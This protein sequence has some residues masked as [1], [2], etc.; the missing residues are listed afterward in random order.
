VGRRKIAGVLVETRTK[1][2]ILAYAVLGIGINANSDVESIKEISAISVSMQ[3]LLGKRI[4]RE[5]L[6]IELL[7][8]VERLYDSQSVSLLSMLREFD[9]SRGRRVVVRCQGKEEIDGVFEDYEELDSVRIGT[10]RG[11]VRVNTTEA[12]SVEYQF[13]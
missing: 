7:A 5:E 6:I 1:G 12:I 8:E 13:D 11:A 3:S 4:F 9:C 10:A 2:N